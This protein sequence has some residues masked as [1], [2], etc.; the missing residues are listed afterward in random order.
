MNP[1]F[2]DSG[3]PGRC[4]GRPISWWLAHPLTTDDVRG[5]RALY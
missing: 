4:R 5:L 2:D 3:T 1:T